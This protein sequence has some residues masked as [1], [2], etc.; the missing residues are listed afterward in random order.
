MLLTHSGIRKS[1]LFSERDNIS[2]FRYLKRLNTFIVRNSYYVRTECSLLFTSCIRIICQ[3]NRYILYNVYILYIYNM[4]TLLIKWSVAKE[5]SM[6][7]IYYTLYCFLF[8][9]SSISES[10]KVFLSNQI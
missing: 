5:N 3:A 2:V 4:Y 1:V 10:S 9:F 8:F 7:Q 6:E